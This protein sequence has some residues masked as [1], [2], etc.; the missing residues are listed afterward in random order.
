MAVTFN[1]KE[2]GTNFV[3]IWEYKAS[4]NGWGVNEK[5]KNGDYEYRLLFWE[6]LK[7][8]WVQYLMWK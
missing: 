4:L 2:V 8:E 1:G 6:L 3:D 7:E 5:W